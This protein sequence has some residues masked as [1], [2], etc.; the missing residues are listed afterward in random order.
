M[1]GIARAR[2]ILLRRKRDKG[3]SSRAGGGV[4]QTAGA[5][6]KRSLKVATV[7]VAVRGFQTLSWFVGIHEASKLSLP[8]WGGQQTSTA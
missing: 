2:G 5:D 4:H 3:K 1:L 7:D 8:E 6:V